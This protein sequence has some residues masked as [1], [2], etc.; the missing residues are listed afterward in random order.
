MSV[1]RR[2]A[3]RENH[4]DKRSSERDGTGEVTRAHPLLRLQRAVGNRAV[5]RLLQAKLD[6]GR[7]DDEHE[8]EADRVAEQVMRAPD[9]GS[10]REG[11][12][13]PC[14]DE[15]LVQ[16]RP[17]TGGAAPPASPDVEARVRG[18]QGK[19]KPLPPSTR[20]FFEPRLGR[21]LGHVRVHAGA[22]AGEAARAVRARAFT[23]GRDVVFGAGQYAPGTVEG[24]KLLAHELAHV[25]QQARSGDGLI[26]RTWDYP[27]ASAQGYDIGRTYTLLNPTRL[28]PQGPFTLRL[29]DLISTAFTVSNVRRAPETAHSIL[30]A[31]ESSS[32]FV[33]MARQLD[34]YYRRRNTPDIWFAWAD[35]SR[36]IPQ[37]EPP[38]YPSFDRIEIDRFVTRRRPERPYTVADPSYQTMAFVRIIVHESAHVYRQRVQGR[39]VTG[40]RGVLRDEART[41]ALESRVMGQVESSATGDLL[42][43]AQ[44]QRR[45]T[46]S[47]DEAEI[48]QDI[49]SATS[50]SYVENHYVNQ[51]LRAIYPLYQQYEGTSGAGQ[52]QGFSSLPGPR[53]MG[54]RDYASCSAAVRQ[55]IVNNSAPPLPVP[56]ATG[57][58]PTPPSAGQ[59]PASPPAVSSAARTTLLNLL[60]STSNLAQLTGAAPQGFSDGELALYYYIVMLEIHHVRLRIVQ[61]RRRNRSLVRGTP[62]HRQF[63]DRI[64]RDYLGDPDAYTGILG[65]PP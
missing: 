59:Q 60:G 64:A 58:G 1:Q 30:E 51:A 19:G 61:E 26:Q 28:R 6:V 41:R 18:L 49:V 45:L 23:V 13:P 24:K 43:E 62:A 56:G 3:T 10:T 2:W 42:R 37:G 50:V 12:A 55:V 22:G 44:Q 35:G 4:K 7:P 20:A 27:P 8:R 54:S 17:V 52:I 5:G 16:P 47:T 33:G 21:D 40:L 29:L 53:E 25:V 57:T 65:P 14:G 36:F 11:A 48:A 31:L 63:L 34:R 39:S 32:L 9:P 38:T 46:G 15:E